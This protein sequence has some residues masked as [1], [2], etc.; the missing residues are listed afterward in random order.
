LIET[1]VFSISLS[2]PLLKIVASVAVLWIKEDPNFYSEIF[3]YYSLPIFIKPY[4][5]HLFPEY[6]TQHW[7][8]KDPVRIYKPNLNRNLIG[9]E[10]RR[11]TIIYQ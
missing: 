10:N 11:R 9:I 3:S 8:G 4:G 7:S 1:I 5:P 2:L 6:L